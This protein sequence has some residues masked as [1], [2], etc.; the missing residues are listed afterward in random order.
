M[1]LDSGE[2]DK[3]GLSFVSAK[4]KKTEPSVWSNLVVPSST[5]VFEAKTLAVSQVLLCLILF[6]LHVSP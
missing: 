1:N 5:L 6:L 4:L 2:G 3:S